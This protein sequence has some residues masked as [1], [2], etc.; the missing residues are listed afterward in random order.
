MSH[1]SYTYETLLALVIKHPN[2]VPLNDNVSFIPS[3]TTLQILEEYKLQFKH[4]T[5]G[6][7]ITY[8]TSATFDELK[9]TEG[10]VTFTPHGMIDWIDIST[11]DITLAFF[12][13]ATKKFIKNTRWQDL[14]PRE[15]NNGEVNLV[16]TYHTY[17][18]LY[19]APTSAPDINSTPITTNYSLKKG[20]YDRLQVALVNFQ[21]VG[22]IPANT[23]KIN[24]I[25]I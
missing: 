8:R 25:I 24:T 17:N 21:L 12:C 22:H 5:T 14:G 20:D 11:L 18:A 7:V 23:N 13:V 3:E 6:F 9:D 2:D 19:D 1:F 10:N 4:T 16:Y 15:K